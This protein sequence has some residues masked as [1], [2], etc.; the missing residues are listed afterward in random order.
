MYMLLWLY[1]VFFDLT[2]IFRLDWCL[3]VFAVRK[4]HDQKA[5]W[6]G[7]GSLP[8]YNLS[9]EGSQGKNM[10]AGADAG[11]LLTGLLGLPS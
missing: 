11:R 1:S 6:G 10:K 3:S 8:D 9:L 2:V 7:K 5:S 4:H